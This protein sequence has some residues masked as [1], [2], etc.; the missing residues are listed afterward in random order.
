MNGAGLHK[1]EEEIK[2]PPLWLARLMEPRLL[3]CSLIVCKIKM[4]LF[5]QISDISGDL[6]PQKLFG[7]QQGSSAFFSGLS[8]P[9][10]WSSALPAGRSSLFPV[11]TCQMDS[12]WLKDP[13][14]I[15]VE[16]KK[17]WMQRHT[18]RFDRSVSKGSYCQIFAAPPQPRISPSPTPTQKHR[19]ESGFWEW[20]TFSTPLFMRLFPLWK[21]SKKS[22]ICNRKP[23]KV[24][25]FWAQKKGI[26]RQTFCRS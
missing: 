15:E 24:D 19:E 7:I 20:I 21:L 6:I 1:R 3:L 2:T 14:I 16:G 13:R 18:K 22:Y 10:A 12:H 8:F 23:N 4:E 26:K 25:L 9:P 5:S 17:G 11:S